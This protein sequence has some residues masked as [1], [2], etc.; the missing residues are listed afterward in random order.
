[1]E[2]HHIHVHSQQLGW[3]SLMVEFRQGFPP[4]WVPVPSGGIFHSSVHKVQTP[5]SSSCSLAAGLDF[6]SIPYSPVE[7]H[8]SGV[9]TKKKVGGAILACFLPFLPFILAHSYSTAL[10]ALHWACGNNWNWQNALHWALT[11][12]PLAPA[13][14]LGE[15]P[16]LQGWVH[17]LGR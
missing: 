2:F 8:C 16:G 17:R 12:F 15:C 10:V 14:P 4:C 5:N 13:S 6:Y 1:M 9:G 11:T 3:D 7:T